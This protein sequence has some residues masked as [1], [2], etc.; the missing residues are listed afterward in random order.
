LKRANSPD[1]AVGQ[2]ARYMGWVKQT[3]GKD[4]E[5]YGVIVAKAISDKLRFARSVVP[6]VLLFEYQVT[7]TL[8]QAHDLPL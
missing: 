1:R 5:V 6:N 8:R 3:I 4:K 2:V 7:F